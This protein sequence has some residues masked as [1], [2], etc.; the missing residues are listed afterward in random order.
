MSVY[1]R[2]KVLEIWEEEEVRS[3]TTNNTFLHIGAISV[4]Y[5]TI[6]ISSCLDRRDRRIGGALE[7]EVNRRPTCSKLRARYIASTY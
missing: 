2:G 6:T 4:P 7:V 3:E 1:S 5:I